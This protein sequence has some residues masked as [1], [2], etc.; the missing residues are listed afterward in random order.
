MPCRRQLSNLKPPL[1]EQ[2]LPLLFDEISQFVQIC[3]RL[4][5]HPFSN[6]LGCEQQFTR[7]QGR[8]AEICY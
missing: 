6:P 4:F 5:I 3:H 1:Q 8:I 7:N 2:S